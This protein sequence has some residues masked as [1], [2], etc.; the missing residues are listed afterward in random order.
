MKIAEIQKYIEL[1]NT[2]NHLFKVIGPSVRKRGYFLF[3][4]F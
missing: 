4:E 1:Y 3:D 2:E